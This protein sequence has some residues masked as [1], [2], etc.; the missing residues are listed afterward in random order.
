MGSDEASGQ[1]LDPAGALL[2]NVGDLELYV[3][4]RRTRV[5][6]S[7]NTIPVAGA[8]RSVVEIAGIGK[9]GTWCELVANRSPS[10]VFVQMFDPSLGTSITNDRVD[11]WEFA[12]TTFFDEVFLGG[13]YP[14]AGD[15]LPWSS[16][17]PSSSIVSVG[18][19][20]AGF[21]FNNRFLLQ[22]GTAFPSPFWI[23]P[24]WLLLLTTF[25]VGQ[26]LNVVDYIIGLPPLGVR[27]T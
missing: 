15:V 12:A 10:Q 4:S 6:G 1:T 13:L 16:Q 7:L 8:R 20:T 9:G 23:P 17:T 11:G 19:S 18:T 26:N 22:A 25:G 14:I 5:S 2:Y 3:P 21:I 24:N 27:G